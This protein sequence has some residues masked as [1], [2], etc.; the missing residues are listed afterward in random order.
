MKY[1]DSNPIQ[2][3]VGGIY[4]KVRRNKQHEAVQLSAR[5]PGIPPT[6]RNWPR[7]ARPTSSK[8]VLNRTSG[9]TTPS[10]QK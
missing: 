7:A 10:D 2:V 5:G 3:P 1:R 6:T 8:S 4:G 9:S